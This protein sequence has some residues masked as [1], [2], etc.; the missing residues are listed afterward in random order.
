MRACFRLRMEL[1]GVTKFA[2]EFAKL[3]SGQSV[4]AVLMFTARIINSKAS[5]NLM[6]VG[7]KSQAVLFTSRFTSSNVKW[8]YCFQFLTD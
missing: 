5:S 4:F 6:I 7:S 1:L 3:L 8:L 2:T